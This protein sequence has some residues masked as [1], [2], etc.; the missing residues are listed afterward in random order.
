[1]AQTLVG[2]NTVTTAALLFTRNVGIA[3]FKPI[4]LSDVLSFYL[5]TCPFFHE[6]LLRYCFN[7]ARGD[8]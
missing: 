1:M 2:R 7:N 8:I 4:S 6:T 5:Y 3:K